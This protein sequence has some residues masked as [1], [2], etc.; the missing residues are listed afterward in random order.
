[1][2][3]RELL[4]MVEESGSRLLAITVPIARRLCQ[5]IYQQKTKC[6]TYSK[7]NLKYR[8]QG[9]STVSDSI[10]PPSKCTVR[11]FNL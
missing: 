6:D 1:M 5:E 8:E 11:S 3:T 7:H 10:M 9:Q 4:H 2:D